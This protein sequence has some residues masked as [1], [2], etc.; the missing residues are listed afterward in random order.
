MATVVD[1]NP[2]SIRGE[3]AL[4]REWIDTAGGTSDC[5][6]KASRD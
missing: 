6:Q 4:L 3:I 2:D 1:A 5:E